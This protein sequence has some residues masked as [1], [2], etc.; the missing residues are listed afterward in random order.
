MV[1]FV[2]AKLHTLHCGKWNI[3][4]CCSEIPAEGIEWV[5]MLLLI[6]N[7]LFIKAVWR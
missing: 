6:D 1:Q 5:E 3:A 7:E 4:Y 2:V